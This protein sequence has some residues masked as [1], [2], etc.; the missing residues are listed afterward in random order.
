[1]DVL[2]HLGGDLAGKVG[3][4]TGD[5]RGREDGAGLENVRGGWRGDTIRRDRPLVRGGVQKREPPF[6]CCGCRGLRSDA[7]ACKIGQGG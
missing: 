5:E 3:A 7:K 1:M 2:G 4:D 6:L